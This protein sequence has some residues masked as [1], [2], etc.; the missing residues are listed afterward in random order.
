MYCTR[1]PFHDTG[2]AREQRVEARVVE[3]FADVAPGREN[4]ALS[5]R[6]DGGKLGLNR[7]VSL[8]SHAALQDDEVSGHA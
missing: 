3:S 4:Q 1:V 6:W 7:T 2:I 8:G 5:V